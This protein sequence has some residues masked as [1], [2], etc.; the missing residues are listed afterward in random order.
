V[1]K[2]NNHFIAIV[3]VAVAIIGVVAYFIFAGRK[4]DDHPRR[5]FGGNGDFAPDS[6]KINST[7]EFFAGN[8]SVDQM[9]SYCGENAQYCFYY[10]RQVN[11]ENELCGELNQ[12]RQFG[13]RTGPRGWQGE[14]G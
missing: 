1:A 3:F 10:C 11:P 14:R 9:K 13:N 7:T 6:G 8:P 4:A 12:T 5:P 2:K